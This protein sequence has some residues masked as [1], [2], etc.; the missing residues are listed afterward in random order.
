[1][2]V[3]TLTQAMRLTSW[4][5]AVEPWGDTTRF[6]SMDACQA[7]LEFADTRAA[8]GQWAEWETVCSWIGKIQTRH[9]NQ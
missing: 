6:A 8:K 1:M 7:L 5:L 4:W 2:R 3:E 9:G